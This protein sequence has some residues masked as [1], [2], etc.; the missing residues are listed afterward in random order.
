MI[1]AV[2]TE[3]Q[4]AA[5]LP[6]ALELGEIR[7]DEVLVRV[8]YDFDQIDEAAHDAE[9]GRT[10]KPVLRVSAVDASS[11]HRTQGDRDD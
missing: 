7:D 6:Q 3:R 4:G 10:I 1:T 11:A 8:F 9:A 2:V 5:I